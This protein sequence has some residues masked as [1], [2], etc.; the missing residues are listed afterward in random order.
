MRSKATAGEYS[1]AGQEGDEKANTG[2][3][4]LQFSAITP[5]VVYRDSFTKSIPDDDRQRRSPTL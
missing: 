3:H 4:C 2:T 5:A 1:H